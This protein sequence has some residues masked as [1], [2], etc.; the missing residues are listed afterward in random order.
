MKLWWLMMVGMLC[1]GLR[2]QSVAPYE[3]QVT[4]Q[5]EDI[6]FIPGLNCH[7]DVWAET[8][9]ALS[10]E[11][12]C[13]VFTLAGFAGVPPLAEGPYLDRYEEAIMEYVETEG[14][15]GVTVVGH[16]LGGYLTLRLGLRNEAAVARLV[17]V[18]ALPFLPG[19]WNPAAQEGMD[20]VRLQQYITSLD[21]LAPEALRGVRMQSAR[22][23]CQD[24]TAWEGIV[25][26]AMASEVRT[27]A[28]AVFE[29]TATDLRQELAGI[30]VPLLMLAPAMAE[31][32]A[33]VERFRQMYAQQ[34][35][36]AP[37]LDLRM[38]AP[39]GHFIMLDEPDIFLQALQDFV[40]GPQVD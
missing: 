38:V 6:L 31:D 12:R 16:S 33:T 21:T 3:V 32:A 9:A 7:G 4:G 30:G 27:E 39:A 24:S 40:G 1:Q 26:W 11:Y 2:A 14:L 20:T 5:G 19:V 23:L 37:H 8:V 17:V 34:Y 15:E 13:H 22:G 18:D 10:G 35:A 36:A 25:N 28:H 29:M